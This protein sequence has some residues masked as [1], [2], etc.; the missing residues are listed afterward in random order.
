MSKVSVV[1]C[2]HDEEEYVGKAL[3]SIYAQTLKPNQV[4]AVLDRCTDNS[5]SVVTS[6]PCDV[7]IE[8]N[9]QRWESSYAENLEMGRNRAKGERVAIVDADMVLPPTYFEETVKCFAEHSNL[10]CVSG[11][12][13]T[14]PTNLLNKLINLWEKTYRFA[15]VGRQ[16]YGCL[17]I[18]REFLNK[19]GGFKDVNTPDTYVISEADKLGAHS[20]VLQHLEVLHV[21]KNTLKSCVE[22]QLSQGKGRGQ[23]GQSLIKSLLHSVIRLRP[24]VFIGHLQREFSRSRDEH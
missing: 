19:M 9:I 15:P 3:E 8:K 22:R 13:V 14:A 16:P 1:V 4:I 7:L 18:S 21:R 23:L 5:K 10:A 24:F 6:Y 12:V 17:V 2:V 20:L 11:G